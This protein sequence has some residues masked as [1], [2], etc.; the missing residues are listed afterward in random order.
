[1]S[2]RSVLESA[3]A[4]LGVITDLGIAETVTFNDAEGLPVEVT[5]TKTVQLTPN[6][7]LISYTYGDVDATATLDIST[8]ALATVTVIPSSWTR[9]FARD[10]TAWYISGGSIYRLDLASGTATML[11]DEAKVYSASGS[12]Q[13]DSIDTGISRGLDPSSWVYADFLG[14]VYVVAMPGTAS[15]QAQ[16]ITSEGVIKNF[17]IPW[18]TEEF[19]ERLSNGLVLIDSDSGSLVLAVGHEIWDNEPGRAGAG[20]VATGGYSLHLYPI[21]LNPSA[22]VVI[23]YNMNVNPVDWAYLSDASWLKLTNVGI[24]YFMDKS[25]L[26]NGDSTFRISS[27][28]IGKC[29]SSDVPVSSVKNGHD[30]GYGFVFNWAYSEGNI[31]AGPTSTDAEVSLLDLSGETAI[32]HDLVSDATISSWSVVGGVLFYTNSVGTYK[33]AID[34]TAGTLGTV[35]LYDGGEVV[36]VTQ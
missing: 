1:M 14:N 20:L 34:T 30:Y 16:V 12:Y 7:V 17:G 18:I 23:S 19:A 33:A 28:S 10:S 25:V 11:S 22:E 4:T 31:Y 13:T 5:V 21:T 24:G 32:S 8:G 15:I 2:G 6:Y 36:A 3:G 26:T 29:N 35:E 27:T 9:I